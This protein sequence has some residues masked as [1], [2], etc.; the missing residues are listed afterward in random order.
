MRYIIPFGRQGLATDIVLRRD[1]DGA[2][3]T[4]PLA[5]ENADADAYRAWLAAGNAPDVEPAP[6]RDIP[7]NVAMW[8]AKAALQHAG[9]LDA[10]NAAIAA[11]GNPVL[12]FFWQSAT[13][14][15]RASSTL[16]RIAATLNM[17]PAQV[18]D[19]FIAAAAIAL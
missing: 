17:T 5:G 11:T 13:S 2:S 8:Q 12:S 7:P 19:L 10:A 3:Y 9:L 4:I 14:I 6:P 16:A 18:D 1:D 15:D